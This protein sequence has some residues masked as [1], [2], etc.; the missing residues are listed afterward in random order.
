MRLQR[1]GHD[2]ATKQQESCQ[3]GIHWKV[4]KHVIYKEDVTGINFLIS[5]KIA[6]KYISPSK[7]TR[8]KKY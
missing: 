5:G 8:Y 1:A 2:I 3:K 4:I 7:K 6:S